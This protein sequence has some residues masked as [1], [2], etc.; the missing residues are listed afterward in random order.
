ML[1]LDSRSVSFNFFFLFWFSFIIR[2]PF[3]ILFKLFSP[4]QVSNAFGSDALLNCSIIFCFIYQTNIDIRNKKLDG[5][6]P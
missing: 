4:V 3:Q 1:D 5:P 6:K 2:L